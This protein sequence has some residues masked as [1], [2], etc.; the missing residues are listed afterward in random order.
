[1]IH[2]LIVDDQEL[3]R[4]GLLTVLGRQSDIEVIG[5]AA[6]GLEALDMV[7]HLV[8]DVVLMDV[9]MP[10]MDGVT[11]AKE[12]RESGAICKVVMLTTFDDEAFVIGAL[13]AGAV[14]YV[15]KNRPVADLA[16]AVRMAHR[17][18]VQ[19]DPA[20]A[21]Q[22]VGRLTR[23][24]DLEPDAEGLA[25]F[26][27]LTEREREVARLVAEGANNREI[28]E[29]LVVSEGTVKTHVSRALG[30]LGLRD[31]TQLAIFIY[32]HRLYTAAS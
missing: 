12:I 26:N 10:V 17:G 16:D 29:R 13:Q 32:Q 11:A 14:G 1:M 7:K 19:L 15:L 24:L 23:S 2:L 4:D 9:R 22:I 8:P 18:V 6:N 25:R 5:A 28:A 31:R 3:M 30:Q 20:A 27:T 21:A